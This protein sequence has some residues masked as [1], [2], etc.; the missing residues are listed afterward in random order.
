MGCRGRLSVWAGTA[1]ATVV[2]WRDHFCPAPWPR[3]GC[4]AVPQRHVLIAQHVLRAQPYET[5]LLLRYKRYQSS[6]SWLVCT[7]GT[8]HGCPRYFQHPVWCCYV[9]QGKYLD[10][11]RVLVR[12]INYDI[13]VCVIRLL[14]VR[15][16]LDACGCQCLLKNCQEL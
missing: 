7:P 9:W 2:W 4:S 11:W 8:S 16:L 13:K 6:F 10:V 14:S 1:A 5:W 3:S 12:A 15:S